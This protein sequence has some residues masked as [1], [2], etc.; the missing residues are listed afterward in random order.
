MSQTDNAVKFVASDLESIAEALLDDVEVLINSL[1]EEGL[2]WIPPH[3]KNNIYTLTNHLLGS[4]R[5]WIGDRIGQIP[6]HRIRDEEFGRTGT[7]EE[8]KA[9][10]AETRSITQR[11][12]EG[13]TPNHLEPAPLDL[14]RG[15]LSW[16]TIPP[17]GRTP[18]WVIV[19]DLCHI[20]YTLGQMNRIRRLYEGMTESG[21]Q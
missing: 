13:L 11:T 10:L 9:S 12:L 20:A 17:E 6:T 18:V 21:L 15:V 3:M 2:N 4:A 16:G 19:H 14:S 1:P 7:L 8:L 5:Y